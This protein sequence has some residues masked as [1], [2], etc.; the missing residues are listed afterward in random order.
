MDAKEGH[1]S[2]GRVGKR[3]DQRHERN[4]VEEGG[5]CCTKKEGNGRESKRNWWLGG[6]DWG[7][8]REVGKNEGKI[9]L[10]GTR[11]TTRAL[12]TGSSQQACYIRG[13]VVVAKGCVMYVEM[14]RL[15]SVMLK[16]EPSYGRF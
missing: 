4:K 5:H 16:K 10:H 7:Y 11:T 1:R 3:G 13:N 9:L 6:L 8:K 14:G 12:E 15:M 2:W